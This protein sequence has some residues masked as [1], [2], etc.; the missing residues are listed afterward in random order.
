MNQSFKQKVQTRKA[1]RHNVDELY[2]AI[3]AGDRI[4]LSTAITLAESTLEADKALAN[5]LVQRCIPHSGNSQRI[6][7]SGVPG[8]GKSTFIE[9]FGLYC[10]AQGKKLAVLAIDPSSTQQHGSILGDKT[11]M[12]VLS[13][14]AN[15]FI[16]PSPSSGALGGVAQ[17]TREA[18]IL[19]EAA[20][21][22][23]IFIETVGVGQSEIAVHSMVDFFLL[24]ML[25]GAGDELQGIKRGIIEIADAIII[26]KADG[27]NQRPAEVAARQYASALHLFPPK[28]SNW[29][30]A[31]AICSALNNWNMDKVWDILDKHHRLTVANGHHAENRKTQNGYWLKEALQQQLFG[32]FYANPAIHQHFHV[33]QDAVLTNKMSPYQGAQELM[34]L[35][36]R[37]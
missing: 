7:I 4:A 20:G 5:Q 30:A 37:N 23:L 15:A 36:L 19:C 10:I 2:T 22:D 6:G 29:F 3:V 21:F 32:A 26:N 12:N 25:A 31:T 13:N 27:E 16:R 17:A 33:I 11:R 24:L 28:D 18:L 14:S 1:Q 9:S 34:H 35:F 8:V